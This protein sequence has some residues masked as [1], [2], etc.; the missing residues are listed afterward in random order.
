MLAAARTDAPLVQADALRLPVPDGVGRRRHLRLRPAQLRRRSSRSS[1]SWPGSSGPAG[2]SRCSRWPSRRTR[3]CAGATASTSARSCP[4]SAACCRTRR[5]TATCRS[6][7]PTCPSRPSCWP[8]SAAPASPTSTA[9]APL[10]RHR[11]AAS[12]APARPHVRRTC[13]SE[14][15]LVARTRRLDARASTCSTVAG[16]T[17]LVWSTGAG[18]V[19]RAGRGPRR[20]RCPP[21][22]RRHRS[23]GR[24]MRCSAR[25]RSTTRLGRPRTGPVALGALPFD[26]DA[27]RRADRARGPRRPGRRRHPLGHHRCSPTTP[28][29]AATRPTS[30]TSTRRRGPSRGWTAGDAALHHLAAPARPTEWCGGAR[31]RPATSCGPARPRRSC[32]PARSSSRPT[33]RS[34]R[35][36]SLRPAPARPIPA[37]MLFAVDGFVGASPEL[38]VAR[39]GD[40]VRSHPMAG[41]APRSG[42][43]PPTP[44]W[45]PRCSP[46]PRTAT[47]T[48]S[49]STWS[50]T[51]CCPGAR[52]STRRPSRRSWPWPTCSTSPPWSRAGSRPRRPRCSS[53]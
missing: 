6:R 18:R 30:A 51:R 40:L 43:P 32:W 41:T 9:H 26:P 35:A 24:R 36:R 1:P 10:R 37:C 12:P 49:R 52:T 3:C 16:E 33:A 28:T 4:A 27:R 20:P 42:D 11:P 15:K 29:S 23:A 44:G 7:W 25:S 19:R 8:C 47:S 31:A 22:T 46:R 14:R 17:G 39:T 38:L 53:W 21:V 5:P 34:R 45:P 2:A 48:G 13:V 50:T